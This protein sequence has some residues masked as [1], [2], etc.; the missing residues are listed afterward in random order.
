[1]PSDGFGNPAGVGLQSPTTVGRL[2]LRDFRSFPEVDVAL[3]PGLTVVQGANGQGKTSLLEAVGWVARTRSFRGVADQLLVRSGT[4]QAVVRAEVVTGAR[5]QLFE[6]EIRVSGR[7]RIQCNRQ[8]VARTRDL[9]G[10]LRV[11]VFSPDDLALVKGGPSERRV[12]LDDLLAMLSPRYDAAGTDFDR[13]LKQRNALLRNGVRDDEARTTLDVFDEQLV[14]AAGELVRGRLR[15][16]ERLLPAVVHGYEA[17]AG[18]GAD[19]AAVYEAEW[20]PEPLTAVDTDAVEDAL[21]SALVAR[22][23]A[24]IERGLTLVGPHRDEWKLTINA[25]DAR[26]QASQ[27]EQRTLALALRLAGHEVVAAL[28]G[29]VPVLLLDDV[30]S[31]L[32]PSRATALVKNLPRGQTLLTTASGVLP[33]IVPDRTLHV[34]AGRVEDDQG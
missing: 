22:R 34:H 30:F 23:R 3:T 26:H 33:G 31:E 17:L 5:E 13:V 2:W 25:L 11:T 9:H 8:P 21:A 18:A 32:D 12:F 24:E 10:L 6:A 20:A 29:T 1:M 27:G 28:T 7:N 15:L 16:I 4:E 19:I 14:R